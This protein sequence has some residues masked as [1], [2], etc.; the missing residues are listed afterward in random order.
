M[1]FFSI[2]LCSDSSF[3]NLKPLKSY[4]LNDSSLPFVLS[5]AAFVLFSFLRFSPISLGFSFVLLLKLGIVSQ[6]RSFLQ[7]RFLNSKLPF[8]DQGFLVL[9]LAFPQYL[10]DFSLVLS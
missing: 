9:V 3:R 6:D 2:S 10:N 1:F 5:V 8:R 7:A 4:S